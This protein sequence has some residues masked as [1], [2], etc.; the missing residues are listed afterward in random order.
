MSNR[1]IPSKTQIG[2]RS[3]R[4]QADVLER[5]R[6]SGLAET[7]YKGLRKCTAG[8]CGMQ[9]CRDVCRYGNLRRR[10]EQVKAA[11]RLLQKCDGPH[12][13]VR[14]GHGA[15]SRPSGSLDKVSLPAAKQLNRRSF[16]L[17]HIPSMAAVGM[18]KVSFSPEDEEGRWK[19]VIHEIVGGVELAD[20]EKAFEA[21][22][23]PRSRIDV[24][25]K[26]VTDLR[27]AIKRVLTVEAISWLQDDSFELTRP[28]ANVRGEYYRWTL[29]FDAGARVIRYGC[30]RH[31]NKLVKKGRTIRP[32]VRK[33][34][35][36]PTWLAPWQFGSETREARERLDAI[37]RM[38]QRR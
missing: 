24:M 21:R 28:K 16:D 27:S 17:L 5:L 33:P 37:E 32:K 30:D 29:H 2:R 31:F 13:E 8:R 9:R 6:R 18:L 36:N 26:P 3:R 25:I 14:V 10:R 11:L 38:H 23:N 1:K 12:F 34:R 20:V 4:A 7:K 35:P 15:W 22:L 19:P